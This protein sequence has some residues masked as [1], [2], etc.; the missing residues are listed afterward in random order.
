MQSENFKHP[1][2][3]VET[4]IKESLNTFLKQSETYEEAFS[5]LYEMYS[6]I[7]P[8]E[9]EKYMF[10]ALQNAEILGNYDD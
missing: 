1:L 6:D 10:E 2:K 8:D 7:S 9:L 5:K 4:N 3:S